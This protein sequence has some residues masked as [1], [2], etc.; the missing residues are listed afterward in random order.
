MIELERKRNLKIRL[1]IIFIIF[2]L[3]IAGNYTKIESS[4]IKFRVHHTKKEST[5]TKVVKTDEI[6][7]LVNKQYK[8]IE[9]YNKDERGWWKTQWLVREL[10][11]GI[12]EIE[13]FNFL[14]DS[15]PEYDLAK[16]K[17]KVT[18]YEMDGKTIKFISKVYKPFQ[19]HSKDGWKVK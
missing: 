15:H 4:Y 1:I 2:S 6:N 18:T 19:I 5:F 9:R 11:D 7:E 16:I 13:H 14:M 10:F 17:Y 8:L 3:M 12:T